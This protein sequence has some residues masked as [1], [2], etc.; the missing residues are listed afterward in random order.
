MPHQRNQKAAGGNKLR[1][2]KSNGHLDLRGRWLYVLPAQAFVLRP[3]AQAR[4]AFQALAG[5]K[6]APQAQT[7]TLPH[8]V[9]P[10]PVEGQSAA[11]A[12]TG[13][14]RT[15]KHAPSVPAEQRYTAWTFGE[16]PELMEIRKGGQTLIGFPAL[17]DQNDAVSIEVFDEPE[18][19]AAKH[20]DGLRRLFA[21]QH[22]F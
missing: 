21:L 8:T 18:V 13:S 10:E 4:G 17:I 2:R 9:R 5:L 3:G 1:T 6:L 22:C 11:R 7:T 20:R 15:E 12:A 14:A 16:L 19:A